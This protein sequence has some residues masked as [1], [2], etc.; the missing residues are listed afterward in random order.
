MKAK[1]ESLATENSFAQGFREKAPPREMQAHLP[2]RVS[3]TKEGFEVMA[4]PQVT[5]LCY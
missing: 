3:L 4:K 2:E 5:G 1:F